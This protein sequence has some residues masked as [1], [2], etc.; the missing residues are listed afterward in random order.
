MTTWTTEVTSESPARAD[1]LGQLGQPLLHLACASTFDTF[2]RRKDS[3]Q[4]PRRQPL[5]NLLARLLPPPLPLPPAASSPACPPLFLLLFFFTSPEDDMLTTTASSSSSSSSTAAPSLS[6][7]SSSS[8]WLGAEVDDLAAS[9]S[10]LSSPSSLLPCPLFSVLWV[11]VAVAGVL[12]V[13]LPS[14]PPSEEFFFGAAWSACWDSDLKATKRRQPTQA[15]PQDSR[16]GSRG[17]NPLLLLKLPR[18]SE[19]K[20]TQVIMQKETPQRVSPKSS[21]RKRAWNRMRQMKKA[22]RCL[23]K[24][25]AS[26]KFPRKRCLLRRS[27]HIYEKKDFPRTETERPN[28]PFSHAVIGGRDAARTE[29]AGQ[30]KGGLGL[31]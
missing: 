11:A 6:C 10:P 29:V 22:S 24:M 4:R 3:H 21:I 5:P 17:R 8:L 26:E 9:P 13:T 14:V 2:L 16:G 1:S 19:T 20:E 30:K 23:K 12:L 28:L 25:P 31:H 15:G 27:L 7:C 18:S